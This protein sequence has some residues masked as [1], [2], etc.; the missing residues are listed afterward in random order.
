MG[1]RTKYCLQLRITVLFS[2]CSS[3]FPSFPMRR[4]RIKLKERAF[5]HCMS[6]SVE[7]RVLFPNREGSSV[8]GEMF[9]VLMGKLASFTGIRILTYALMSNHYHIE[10][11]VPEALEL[12]DEDL[13][14]RIEALYG[15]A[16][17]EKIARKLNDRTHEGGV[18]QQAQRI[19]EGFLRRMFDVSEFNKELKGRFAQWYNKRHGRK[20]T[21][22]SERFKSL[23]L[24][25]GQ[26]VA[27]VAAYIDLNPVRALLCEDPKDYRYCGYAQALASS[28]PQRWAGIGIALGLGPDTSWQEVR[29]AYRKFLFVRGLRPVDGSRAGFDEQT[30]ERVVEKEKGELSVP[31]LLRAKIQYF[32]AGVIV[33][34]KAFVE[35]VFERYSPTLRYKRQ[36]RYP[37][38]IE[39]IGAMELWAFRRGVSSTQPLTP[40][41][42]TQS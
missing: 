37:Y 38:R 31:Q 3:S 36:P 14:A 22:W 27:A 5:Y 42:S 28:G 21:L 2:R 19:R 17:R 16:T 41:H 40:A 11:E 8:E 33:G 32:S 24:G 39:G 9:L 4:P 13:L 15:A 6:R 20:G 7:D 10:C 25:E 1:R 30:V 26:A 23:V 18:A 34:A 35:E 29:R 12:C